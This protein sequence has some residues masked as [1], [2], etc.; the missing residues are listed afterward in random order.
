MKLFVAGTS[1]AKGSLSLRT[2]LPSTLRYINEVSKEQ[3]QQCAAETRT[4]CT[5]TIR[6]SFP[7]MPIPILE[8]RTHLEFLHQWS[9]DLAAVHGTAEVMVHWK[10]AMSDLYTL[11]EVEH[12]HSP[13]HECVTGMHQFLIANSQASQLQG[14]TNIANL[15]IPRLSYF[16]SK[17]PE[18]TFSQEKMQVEIVE[19]MLCF[20]KLMDKPAEFEA[21]YPDVTLEYLL[22]LHE[23]FVLIE[24]LSE[25]WV[26]WVISKCSCTGFFEAG[27]CWHSLRFAM[28]YDN[29]LQR[30][31]VLA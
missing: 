30:N 23:S 12:L 6:W 17:D 1:G 28:L 13:L 3:A 9:L 20:C 29:S 15:A 2:V 4:H 19:E 10:L 14:H 31:R 16:K 26:L 25:K 8:D 21:W 27:I 22:F 18:G 5:L 7:G 11:A 24:P